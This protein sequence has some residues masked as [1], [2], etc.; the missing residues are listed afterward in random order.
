MNTEEYF[1]VKVDDAIV[2][3]KYEEVLCLESER[4]YVTIYCSD[5]RKLL[6]RKTL[7]ALNEIL[8]LNF[9]RVNR[10]YIVNMDKISKLV[11]SRI[12]IKG[13]KDIV[14]IISAKNRLRF[15]EAIPLI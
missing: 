4:N 9:V 3:L 12:Y 5:G 10:S 6:I 7:Q 13:L 8:P 1:F 15:F 2:L 11:G 14:P